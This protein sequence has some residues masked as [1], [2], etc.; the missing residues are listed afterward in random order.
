MQLQYNIELA[1]DGLVDGTG[2]SLSVAERYKLLLDRRQRWRYLKWR[3]VDTFSA[4]AACQAYELVDG[5]FASSRG[6]GLTGSRHLAITRLPTAA[7]G[8]QQVERDDIGFSARDF[9]MDPSRD[10]I[11]LVLTDGIA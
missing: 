3:K 9:A 2:C 10:L 7:G 8:V 6:F 11:A 1:A 5:V 4:P